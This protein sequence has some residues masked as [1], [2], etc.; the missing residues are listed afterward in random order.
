MSSIQEKF[1]VDLLLNQP[2]VVHF[3]SGIMGTDTAQDFRIVAEGGD[4]PLFWLEAVD[5][6]EIVFPVVDPYILCPDYAPEF[7]LQDLQII[8]LEDIRDL[9]L[10]SLVTMVNVKNQKMTVN[11]SAPLLIN[12]EKGIGKQG[13]LLNY[14][15][16]PSNYPMSSLTKC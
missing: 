16:F 14:K 15:Q 3:A 12:W 5:M 9:F 2:K 13:V 10:L 6:K 11:L 1:I 8:E 7:S 4:S